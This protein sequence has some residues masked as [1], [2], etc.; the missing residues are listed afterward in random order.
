M[1]H[2]LDTR[3]PANTVVLCDRHL[4]VI[5]HEQRVGK[6]KGYAVQ[7]SQYNNG[8]YTCF[9][10]DYLIKPAVIGENVCEHPRGTHNCG[11]TH[12]DESDLARLPRVSS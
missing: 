5:L 7:S 11:R 6:A 4:G 2:D 9:V 10:P 12:V 8:L 3:Y 1:A